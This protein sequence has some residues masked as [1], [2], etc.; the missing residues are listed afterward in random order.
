MPQKKSPWS[1]DL[2]TN[3]I[4]FDGRQT[5]LTTDDVVWSETVQAKGIVPYGGI[6][7]QTVW[8]AGETL[9][10][11]MRQLIERVVV[12]EPSVTFSPEIPKYYAANYTSKQTVPLSF[13]IN[14]GKYLNN[15]NTGCMCSLRIYVNGESEASYQYDNVQ[16]KTSYTITL[17]P[18]CT[19]VDIPLTPSFKHYT[20]YQNITLKI[21]FEYTDGV[22]PE[23]SGSSD[24]YEKKMSIKG[25][26]HIFQY[27]IEPMQPFYYQFFGEFPTLS[28]LYFIGWDCSIDYDKDHVI[29]CGTG[30]NR[31]VLVIPGDLSSIS[32]YHNMNEK[33]CDGIDCSDLLKSYT[34]PQTSVPGNSYS[35][36]C[37]GVFDNTNVFTLKVS[38]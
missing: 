33:Y 7:L 12:E 29:R 34:F 3:S 32:L 14:P 4:T 24:D 9:T 8:E 2:K 1:Y 36:N 26:T 5:S 19:E 31:L 28:E 37:V 35:L 38:K 25:Q 16:E 10:D 17:E 6:T 22:I 18:E 13:I 23:I 21:I 15:Q 27:V 30:I 11:T 20:G